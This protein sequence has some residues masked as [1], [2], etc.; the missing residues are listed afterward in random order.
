MSGWNSGEAAGCAGWRVHG[1]HP[2]HCCIVKGADGCHVSLLQNPAK[3]IL[4]G[5]G[6]S[7]FLC[8]WKD[9]PREL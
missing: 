1:C 5:C 4:R 3:G 2:S 6:D 9:R 7:D 8:H